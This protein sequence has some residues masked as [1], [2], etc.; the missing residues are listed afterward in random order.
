MTKKVERQEVQGVGAKEEGGDSQYSPE[1]PTGA[2]VP[3]VAVG[4]TR[5]GWV[6]ASAAQSTQAGLWIR[7]RGTALTEEFICAGG[8]RRSTLH[9]CVSE[10]AADFV[11]ELP[12]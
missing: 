6:A 1:C 5:A 7:T 12:E 4:S 3:L 11:L 9:A 10:K 8:N 2:V